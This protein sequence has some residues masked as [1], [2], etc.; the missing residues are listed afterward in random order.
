MRFWSGPLNLAAASCALWI[1]AAPQQFCVTVIDEDQKPVTGLVAEDFS[2]RDAGPRQPV[3]DAEPARDGVTVAIAIAGFTAEMHEHLSRSVTALTETM[4]TFSPSS[5]VLLPSDS[6][7]TDSARSVNDVITAAVKRASADGPAT[8][9][10]VV[11]FAR[12]PSGDTNAIAAMRD[13]LVA[14]QTAVWTVE[15]PAASPAAGAKPAR[16]PGDDCTR[17]RRAGERDSAVAGRQ[18]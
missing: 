9:R 2:L 7:L 6:P 1:S 10:A 12:S 3:L 14:N 15:L 13:L 16:T 18:A 17:R 11:L 8:R 5:H 4:R